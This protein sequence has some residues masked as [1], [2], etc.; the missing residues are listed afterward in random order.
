MT[1][2]KL[3][4]GVA[5]EFLGE[6]EEMIDLFKN[7]LIAAGLS[8]IFIYLVLASLYE[9]LILPF[10]IMLALPLAIVGGLVAIFITGQS[11]G[12]FTMI[13]FIMLLGLVTK[14]SILLVDYTQ[15]LMRKGLNHDE[16][17]IKAGIIRLRP[18]LMTTFAL[19]AGMLPLA[20]GLGEMG[21][22]RMSMGIAIIGGL[23]S[24]T[25]LTLIVI[26]AVFEYMDT[27][28][29]WLRRLVGRPPLREIDK[30][31]GL[32]ELPA[33]P[34]AQTPAGRKQGQDQGEGGIVTGLDNAL[35]E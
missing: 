30:E 34:S 1:Q 9:S 16:A 11:L 19:I 6:T 33:E 35:S 27:F 3:P 12:M 17:L 2:E 18:I 24:S 22:F 13:G 23:L 4:D 25:A 8:I 31:E 10:T 29:L 20:L 7:M 32:Q 14:N 5:F 28:R 15:K 21:K 26:P